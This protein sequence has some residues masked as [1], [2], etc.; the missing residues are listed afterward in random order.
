MS[1]NCED[2]ARHITD[3]LRIAKRK[4]SI[5]EIEKAIIRE[6]KQYDK[7]CQSQITEAYDRGY[8]DGCSDSIHG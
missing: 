7:K 8:R 5:D 6:F 2:I 4:V 3:Y 1:Q